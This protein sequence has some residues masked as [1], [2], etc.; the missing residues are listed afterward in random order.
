MKTLSISAILVFL[1]AAFIGCN[2]QGNQP[3][4]KIEK[5]DT[6]AAENATEKNTTAKEETAMDKAAT[7]YIVLAFQLGKHD[8]DYVDA[9]F[10]PKNLKEV[11]K[12]NR[13]TLD[14][15]IIL[16][17]AQLK[18][19]AGISDDMKT[20]EEKMRHKTLSGMLRSLKGRVEFLSGKKMTFDQES[21]ALYGVVAPSYPLSHYDDIL[22]KLN[23]LL[24]GKEPLHQ[25]LAD[26]KNPFVIPADKME[27][28]FDTAIAEGRKRT[29]EFIT[30]PEKET[31]L[32]EYVKDKPWGAYNWFKGNCQ[33]LIQIN[34]DIVMYIDRAV[35]L[36]CHEGYPGHHV[37]YTLL[38]Q[39]LYKEKGWLEYSIYPLFG[40]QSLIA[41]GTANFGIEVVFPRKERIAFEKEVLFPLAGLKPDNID[42]YY[43]IQ[44]LLLKLSFAGNDIA[45]DYL[46]GKISKDEAVERFMKYQLR[47]RKRAEKYLSFIDRYRSYIINYNLGQKMVGDYIKKRG[48]TAD[49]PTKLR[50]EFK[51]LLL[52]PLLPEDLEL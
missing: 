19:M 49:N 26:F 16:A 39:K 7:A 44:S 10:G 21:R 1:L 11:A 13:K 33:S 40:P 51:K 27:T 25:R 15:I 20:E 42:K 34:T 52:T 17:E 2:T 36:A 35:G 29:A 45:R 18:V 24:P 3:D 12:K 22:A 30:L 6:Q 14:E 31:F 32:M 4:G 47:T 38:E 50:Q 8:K 5:K 46:D 9:Y 37:Y 28:V 41:E 43:D 48:G 23:A